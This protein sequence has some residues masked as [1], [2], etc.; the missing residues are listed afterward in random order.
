MIIIISKR[1]SN[2]GLVDTEEALK[3]TK[4]D[5]GPEL[6]HPMRIHGCEIK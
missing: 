3:Q 1:T 5:Q 6:Q 4:P 2:N